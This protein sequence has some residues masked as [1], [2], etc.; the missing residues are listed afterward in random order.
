M[1]IA[2]SIVVVALWTITVFVLVGEICEGN[3][4]ALWHLQVYH[5]YCGHAYDLI[6]GIVISDVVMDVMVL[7][8]P[9][10]PVCFRSRT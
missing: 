8:L 2:A 4:S 3:F 7:L 1:I 9:I 10:V 5:Q 6:Y